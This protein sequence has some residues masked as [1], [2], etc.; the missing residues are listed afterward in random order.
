MTVCEN[1]I[2][3]TGHHRVA[4]V[5]VDELSKPG[6]SGNGVIYEVTFG[7]KNFLSRLRARRQG[8]CVA[9]IKC[10]GAAL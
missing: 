4:G 7:V 10:R 8:A 2:A 1:L 5:L 6:L 3:L 9:L